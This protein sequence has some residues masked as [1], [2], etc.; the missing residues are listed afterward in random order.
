[1]GAIA[2]ITRNFSW[3]NAFSFYHFPTKVFYIVTVTSY[4]SDYM[5]KKFLRQSE[6][7]L[8]TRIIVGC[9]T[10]LYKRL[11]KLLFN[12]EIVS[13]DAKL[14]YKVCVFDAI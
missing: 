7:Q 2:V 1:M 4:T 6:L 11:C 10:V 9:I 8:Q 5:T 3:L 12:C 14:N 13:Y